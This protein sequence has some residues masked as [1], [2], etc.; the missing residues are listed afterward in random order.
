MTEGPISG[1][2]LG[3]GG[4]GLGFGGGGLGF[5]GGGL[6]GGGAKAVVMAT[7]SNTLSYLRVISRLVFHELEAHILTCKLSPF[8]TLR[9]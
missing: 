7:V 2:G 3:F 4:G 6:G 8:E 9:G 1:G 5:G